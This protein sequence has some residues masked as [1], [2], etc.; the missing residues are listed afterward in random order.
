VARCLIIGCGGRGQALARELRSRGNVVRGTTRTAEHAAA[1]EAAGA[2]AFIGDPDRLATLFGA[3]D[4]VSVAYILLGSA[5]G[6]P[7]QVAALHGDRLESLV[8][9]MIDTTIRIVIY[10][11]AGSVEQE[12]LDGGTAIV[13][14]LCEEN[15]MLYGFIRTD[16]ADR[17]GWLQAAVE[18][19]RDALG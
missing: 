5:S 9:K 17:D 13:T 10:E 8:F 15:R 2:E 4:H 6:S 16:P 19:I 11:A 18:A 3:L 12:L 14:R 7:E 1:I